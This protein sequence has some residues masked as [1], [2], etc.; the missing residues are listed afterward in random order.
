MAVALNWHEAAHPSIVWGATGATDTRLRSS[1][2]RIDVEVPVMQAQRWSEATYEVTWITDL[3]AV[4]HRVLPPDPDVLTAI[5][6][7]HDLNSAIADLVDNSV[8]AGATSILIRFVLVD[9][10][11]RSLLVVDDGRGMSDSQLDQAM[12]IGRRRSYEGSDLGHFGMGLKSASFS[13][14]DILTVLT[15]A[16][17]APGIG[18]R[19]SRHTRD[20]ICDVIDSGQAEQALASAGPIANSGHG[21]IVRWDDVREF[22]T[23]DNPAVV[24]DYISRTTQQIRAHLGTTLHALLEQGKVTVTIDAADVTDGSAGAPQTV[25]AIDPFGYRRSGARGYPKTLWAEVDHRRI[26]LE[27]HIWPARSEA[28]GFRLGGAAEQYQG[29]YFYRN[30]RLLEIGGWKSTAIPHRRLQL[31]RVAIDVSENID[32]INMNMEKSA[33]QP[34]PSLLRGIEKAQAEDGT[35]FSDYLRDAESA[36]KLGNT[37]NTG[38]PQVVPPGPGIAPEVKRA[39]LEELP[40]LG[41][42]EPVAIRWKRLDNTDFFEV[43]RRAATLWLNSRYRATVNGDRRSSLNDSPLLKAALY[44]LLEDIFRGTAFGPRDK[45]NVELWQ[46]VLSAAAQAEA[47]H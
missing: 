36:Y 23:S 2:D 46:A 1:P 25:E 41:G 17:E 8:D 39:I 28:L 29:L 27:C 10:K 37:R 14:A 45:D 21:T 9:G 7:S 13:Q 19:W 5:G 38:R 6:L 4:D 26:A 20:F 43:D 31:A 32:L 11:P 30:R 42:R 18:R 33:V 47:D 12:T 35:S 24:D 16:A 34:K 40:I 15:R 22:P 44:L 3:D